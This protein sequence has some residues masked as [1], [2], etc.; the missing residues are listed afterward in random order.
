MDIFDI[1]PH[2]AADVLP[3]LDDDEIEELAAD[4]RANGL[5]MPLL[6]GQ[7]DGQTV[8]VDGR[9][10]REACRRLG[11]VP[12]ITYC[13]MAQTPWPISSRPIFTGAI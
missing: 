9:N 11:I 13:L 7:L 4:I 12:P 5:L 6:V 8:L 10:R 2:P 3:M 1:P